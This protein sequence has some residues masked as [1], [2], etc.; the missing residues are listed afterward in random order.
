MVSRIAALFWFVLVAKHALILLFFR[1]NPAVGT[2]VG[3]IIVAFFAVIALFFTLTYT[4]SRNRGL[5]RPVAAKVLVIFLLWTA[6]T[7]LWTMARSPLIAFAYW[8]SLALEALVV[9]M[10]MR[11]GEIERIAISSLKGIVAGAAVLAVV[12]LVTGTHGGGGER[13]GEDIFL[14]PNTIG[15]QMAIAGLCGIYLAMQSN[16]KMFVRSMWMGL[17]LLIVFT[18]FQTL[19]KT[20]ISAFAVAGLVFL[21]FSRVRISRKVVIALGILVLTAIV[22]ERMA[23]HV[24]QYLH[25]GYGGSSAASTLS[26]RTVLWDMTWKAIQKE[27]WLGHGLLSFRDYMPAVHAHNEWLT[28]WFS[29]GVVGV[30]IAA[31]F[32]I[33][34]LMHVIKM[35]WRRHSKP[36]ALLGLALLIFSL[37]RGITE[38]HVI[39]LVFSIPLATFVVSWLCILERTRKNNEQRSV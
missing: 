14:H 21:F 26:G 28:L 31:G 5:L 6:L 35:A 1:Q 7:I 24:E 4:K 3:G 20:A 11:L 30:I 2:L 12:A 39:G 33:S 32:Y 38:A 25:K 27:P 13:L 23:S 15:N 19:S 8:S 9:F 16:M 22:Y 17:V 36:P 10:L 18:L 37:I 34:M 29:Y